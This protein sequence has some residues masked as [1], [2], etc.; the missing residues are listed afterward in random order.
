MNSKDDR[1]YIDSKLIFAARN[2]K[3]KLVEKTLDKPIKV[4][5][6]IKY[7]KLPDN[8]TP[9]EIPD[10]ITPIEEKNNIKENI[11]EKSHQVR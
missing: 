1:C 11:D 3:I 6:K 8:I 10:N 4:T 5:E 2:G 9:I 7:I